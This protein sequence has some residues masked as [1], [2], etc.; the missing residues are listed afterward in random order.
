MKSTTRFSKQYK[1]QSNNQVKGFQLTVS[2]ERKQVVT[3]PRLAPRP[4]NN[5]NTNITETSIPNQ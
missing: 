3:N 1:E 2:K 5:S 4:D